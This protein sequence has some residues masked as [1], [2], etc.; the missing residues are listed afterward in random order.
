MRKKTD[1]F[2]TKRWDSRRSTSLLEE[3]LYI[4]YETMWWCLIW[5]GEAICRFNIFKNH[6]KPNWLVVLICSK[7]HGNKHQV[8]WNRHVGWTSP[9]EIKRFEATNL[10]TSHRSHN[11]F[12]VGLSQKQMPDIAELTAASAPCTL[13]LLLLWFICLAQIIQFPRLT[14]A[15]CG[16]EFWPEIGRMPA[17]GNNFDIVTLVR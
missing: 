2:W 6:P 3:H 9:R 8:I 14:L 12:T 15:W 1:N 13:W 17:L 4:P 11:Q 16:P 5:M 10:T 7:I